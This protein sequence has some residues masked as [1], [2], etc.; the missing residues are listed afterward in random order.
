MRACV[1]MG[2]SNI[3]LIAREMPCL[4]RI[5]KAIMYQYGRLISKSHYIQCCDLCGEFCTD[6]ISHRLCFCMHL[7]GKRTNLWNTF[8][9]MYGDEAF[10]KLL[11]MLP[12]AQCCELLKA[13]ILVENGQTLINVPICKLITDMLR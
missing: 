5:C 1:E 13:A 8:I 9:D 4:S 12:S 2:P 10:L 6:R 3:W 11:K 7:I